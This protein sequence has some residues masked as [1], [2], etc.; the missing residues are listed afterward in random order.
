LQAESLAAAALLAMRT[1]RAEYWDWY[2]RIWDY[3]WGNFVDHE[4]GAW[5]RI[6]NRDN[7]KYGDE[8]SPA[9]KVDYHTMGA[10]YEVLSV[11]AQGASHA[12]EPR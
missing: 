12:A 9:G 6:L 8:K 2:Q 7:H 11:L 4:H 5:Y 3:S 1:G 10:C